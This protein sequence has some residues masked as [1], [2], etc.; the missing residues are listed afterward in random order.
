MEKSKMR[1][2]ALALVIGAASLIGTAAHAET[3][4]Y[5]GVEGTQSHFSDDAISHTNSTGVKVYGGYNFTTHVAFEGEVGYTNGF[6]AVNGSRTS[7]TDAALDVKYSQPLGHGLSAYGKVGM[8]YQDINVSNVGSVN[9]FTPLFGAGVEYGL[10]K[11]VTLRLEDELTPRIANVSD[12]Y[13]SV[14]LGL[15][16][17]F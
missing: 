16:Y 3:P 7:L 4:F 2:A 15:S 8:A 1:K 5:L 12:V 17:R 11:K 13:N 14:N 9:G 6:R 10:T